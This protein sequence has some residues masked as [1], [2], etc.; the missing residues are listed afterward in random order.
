MV[1][2]ILQR[3]HVAIA[4]E[5]SVKDAVDD[6][7]ECEVGGEGKCEHGQRDA[8]DCDEAGGAI[9]E[10]DLREVAAEHA[11]VGEDDCHSEDDGEVAD[12]E[13]SVACVGRRV[14]L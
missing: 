13:G 5:E 11:E 4:D 1:I 3:R 9:G 10:G 7:I 8:E 14:P 6:D 12:G 2:T